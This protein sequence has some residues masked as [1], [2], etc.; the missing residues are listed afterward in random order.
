MLKRFPLLGLK[1]DRSFISESPH[2]LD[3]CAI[4]SAIIS[5]AKTLGLEVLAEGVETQAQA[6][7][8]LAAGCN[9]VQG[10]LLGRPVPPEE[11]EQLLSLG[12]E[13]SMDNSPWS[14]LDDFDCALV[15]T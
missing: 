11:L 6:D 2:D 7:F 12:Q 9:E 10:F 5:L 8:L 14:K 15:V 1:I 13:P 3:D 4:V